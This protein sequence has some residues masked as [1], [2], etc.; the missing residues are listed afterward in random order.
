MTYEE[1]KA[2][3]GLTV[4]TQLDT[5]FRDEVVADKYAGRN[6]DKM[7]RIGKRVKPYELTDWSALNGQRWQNHQHSGRKGGKLAH[8]ANDQVQR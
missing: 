2:M 7:K 6:N 4:A 5:G 1:R 3:L 8:Q